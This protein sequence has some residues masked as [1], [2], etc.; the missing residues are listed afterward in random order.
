M[1][2]TDVELDQMMAKTAAALIKDAMGG[3]GKTVAE[4]VEA[5]IKKTFE[6]RAAIQ[7]EVPEWLTQ[8]VGAGQ[9]KEIPKRAKGDAAGRIIRAIVPVAKSKGSYDNVVKKLNEWG[10]TDL[11]DVCKAAGSVSDPTAGGYLVPEQYSTDVIELLRPMSVVRDMVGGSLPMPVG[12]L[13][14]PKITEGLSAFYQNENAPATKTLLRTG[15]LKLTWRKLTALTAFS[16]D[17]GRY[18]NPSYDAIVRKDMVKAIAQREN[19]AF[20]RDVGTDSAPKGMRHLAANALSPIAANATVNLTNVT[21]DL[22]KMILDLLNDNVPITKGGWIFAPRTYMFLYTLLTTNGVFAFRDELSR[23][24]LWGYPY[25]VTTSV[26]IN[27][28]THG[29]TTESEIYFA[30]FD[31]L[32]IGDSMALRI[33]ASDSASYTDGGAAVSAFET[34]QTV[35]RGITEH[36]FNTRRAESISIMDGVNWQ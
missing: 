18:S 14:I 34:D 29:G 17:L 21:V 3:E 12:T 6:E 13:M 22:G 16:N 9:R 15:Q 8:A 30:D 32:V 25:R 7:K 11:A 24:T 26:P 5:Q 2:V 36:D 10:D 33:D 23:G 27:L 19:Q 28:T 35:V 4:V 31:D 1:K 20:L